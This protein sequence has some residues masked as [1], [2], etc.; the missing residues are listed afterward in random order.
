M[1]EL[2]AEGELR[3]GSV[4]DEDAQIAR[5]QVEP[6]YRL[7]DGQRDPLQPFFTTAST[8]R[9]GMQHQEL[10]TQCQCPFHLA[11]KGGDGLGM[12]LRIAACKIDQ[13]VGVD[14]QRLQ[15]ILLAQA[16]HRVALRTR[17]FIRLPLPRTGGE[18]L[19]RVAA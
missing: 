12:K 5:R 8:E 4:F 17:Q 15:C 10:S 16:I 19:E 2:T 3:S 1:F 18:N 13:V 11:T 9:A 6:I 7:L 14:D